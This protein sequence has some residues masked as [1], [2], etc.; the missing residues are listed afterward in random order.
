MA[1]RDPVALTRRWVA[2]VVVGL[3]LC[4]FAAAP[5]RNIALLRAMGAA[6]LTLRDTDPR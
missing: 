6:A 2:R 5:A 3:D 1:E 4:P